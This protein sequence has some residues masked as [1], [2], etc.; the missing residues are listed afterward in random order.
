[1]HWKGSKGFYPLT[2]QFPQPAFSIC[3]LP[4]CVFPTKCCSFAPGS[5][6][7]DVAGCQGTISEG[8]QTTRERMMLGCVEVTGALVH[9][10]ELLASQ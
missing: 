9:L 4:W 1:V 8:A 10:P 6:A 2:L 3:S 5:A 7:P